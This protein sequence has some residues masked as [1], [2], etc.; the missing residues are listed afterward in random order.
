MP[1]PTSPSPF[2]PGPSQQDR[3]F[4]LHP[5]SGPAQRGQQVASHLGS[6]VLKPHLDHS[7]AEACLCRQRL[8]DLPGGEG[9]GSGLGAGAGAAGQGGGGLGDLRDGRGRWRDVPIPGKS[10]RPLS[11]KAAGVGCRPRPT[12]AAPHLSAGLGGHLEGGLEG[13]SLLRGEDGPGSLGPPGVFPVVPTAFTLAALPL[14]WLHVP[15]LVLALHCGGHTQPISLV[16]GSQIGTRRPSVAWRDPHTSRQHQPP[17]LWRPQ[18]SWSASEKLVPAVPAQGQWVP[19][20]SE[21]TPG[22]RLSRKL[23]ETKNCQAKPYPRHRSHVMTTART[24]HTQLH[25]QPL[26]CAHAH[27]HVGPQ[28][29]GHTQLTDTHTHTR[30]R[31]HRRGHTGKHTPEHT[32]THTEACVFT[33]RHTHAHHAHTATSMSQNCGSQRCQPQADT[34]RLPLSPSLSWSPIPRPTFLRP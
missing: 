20:P 22:S 24:P 26:T 33:Q 10:G 3:V 17:A 29:T 6:L 16:R 34:M 5:H 15:V 23:P 27:W 25:T 12:P 13:S 2:S 1:V 9:Q 31:A 11:G 19:Q 14:G 28:S 30:A 18:G 7:H 21:E 8:S 4:C 32:R